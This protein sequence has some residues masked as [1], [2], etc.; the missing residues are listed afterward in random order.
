MGVL[1]YTVIPLDIIIFPYI[2]WVMYVTQLYLWKV[3]V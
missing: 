1:E 2:C 3:T